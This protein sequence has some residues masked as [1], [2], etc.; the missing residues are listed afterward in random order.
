MPDFM[1]FSVA[2]LT[3]IALWACSTVPAPEASRDEREAERRIERVETGLPSVEKDGRTVGHPLQEWMRALGVPGLS[4]AVIDRYEIAWAKGYGVLEAGA[5][6]AP[7]T[8]KTLFQAA[9]IAKPVAALAVLHHVERGSLDLDAD[10]NE[11]LR[12]WK[13][14]G[15]GA[16]GGERVT[17]RHLLAHT[18][19]ITPGGFVG[20]EREAAIPTITQILEGEAPASNRPARVLSAPGSAVSYSGLGYTIVQLALEDRLGKPFEKIIEES[21]FDPVGMR[22]STFELVL[23]DGLAARAARGHW[24]T[25]TVLPG[26]WY[27]YPESAAAGLWTTAS[28][29]ARLAIEVANSRQG[30]SSRI[31]SSEMTR[32]MLTQH[33]DRMGL[34][35]VIRPG[36]ERGYFAHSGGNLGFRCHFEMLADTGQGVVVM[37]N[38]DVGH[39]VTQL[40]L[41]SVARAYDWPSDRQQ[42]V[43][44]ALTDALFAQL[45]RSKSARKRIEVDDRILARHV[46]RYELAP[47][48]VFEVTRGAGHLEVRLGE[49]PRFQV[50]PESESKFFYE[51]VDAQITFVQNAAGET[52]SLVLHQGGREQEAKKIE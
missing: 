10:V 8:E 26:G 16:V 43:S 46:G 30:S 37:T 15:V 9:S 4:L 7:V 49:Q 41:T 50:Y 21:V 38:S 47:G 20:Y 29:L 27:V 36:D 6:E 24:L 31:L 45:D 22:D 51:A 52:V 44:A 39:L 40:V 48:L 2:L 19:G 34:G 1:R 12:S 32:Q 3:S 28:D 17:L 33:R 42:P 18:A 5:G 25:G 23:P 14:P 35:F 11:Y 13:L